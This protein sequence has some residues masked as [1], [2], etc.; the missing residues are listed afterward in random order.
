MFKNYVISRLTHMSFW[1]GSFILIAALLLP[2]G[3]IICA[4][5]FMILND[6]EWWRSKMAKLEPH[7]K[8]LME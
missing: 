5:I 6:D 2:R 8:K 7:I 3:F 4:G 1:M